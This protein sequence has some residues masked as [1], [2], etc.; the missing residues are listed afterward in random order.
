MKANQQ[1]VKHSQQKSSKN[2]KNSS[3]VM[4]I[5]YVLMLVLMLSSS[6]VRIAGA[7]HHPQP[8]ATSTLQ[9]NPIAGGGTATRIF[10]FRKED[11]GSGICEDLVIPATGSAVYSNCGKSVEKQYTL[12]D[13]E[14]GR[15]QGWIGQFET[16]NYDHTDHSQT[17]DVTTQLYLNGQGS[18]QAGDADIQ[19]MIDFAKA[20]AT[21]TV[22]QQ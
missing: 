2:D 17:G 1:P 11:S 18:Q 6:V 20:L 3:G 10:V 5:F 8:A 22:S 9:V 19:S 12:S 21:K 13:S 14:R 16:V 15:L 7:R 4:R